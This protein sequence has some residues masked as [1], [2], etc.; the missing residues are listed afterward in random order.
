MYNAQRNGHST[1]VKIDQYDKQGNFIASYRSFHLAAKAVQGNES[2]IK[3]AVDRYG[4]S[5]GYFWIREGSDISIQE[6]L[7]ITSSGKPK[8]NYFGVSQYDLQGNFIAHYQSLKE[9]GRSIEC[10]D[11]TIKRAAEACR[12]GKSYYWILDNQNIDIKEII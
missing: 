8:S 9:A 1:Q 7:N 4:T 3:Q 5:A 6:V 11:S 12:P 2:A 10:A